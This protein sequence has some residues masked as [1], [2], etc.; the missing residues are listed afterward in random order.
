MSSE[1]LL[2]EMNSK[3]DDVRDWQTRQTVVCESRGVLL[4]ELKGTL[5]GNGK[6]GLVK[7]VDRINQVARV[8]YVI[9]GAGIAVTVQIIAGG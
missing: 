1:E 2:R 8:V 5:F 6:P 4:G 9:V 3:L 7:V